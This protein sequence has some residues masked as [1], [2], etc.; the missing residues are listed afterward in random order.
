MPLIVLSGDEAMAN[1]KSNSAST[2]PARGAAGSRLEPLARPRFSPSFQLQPGE[3]IFTIG[4]CF[5]RNI[6]VMLEQAGFVIPTRAIIKAHAEFSRIGHNVLNN[7]GAPSI[8][9]EIRWALDDQHPFVEE[10]AFFEIYPG[11]YIDAHLNHALKPDALEDVRARRAAILSCYRAISECRVIIITLGLAECWLDRTTGIYLNTAP[12]RS[13]IREFP[14]RFELHVLSYD[15]VLSAMNAAMELIRTHGHPEARVILTVSPVPLTSTFRRDDVMVANTYSKA[16]LRT[17][18]EAIT[19]AYDFVDY[20]PSYESVTLSERSVALLEDQVHPSPEVIQLNTSRMIRAYVGSDDQAHFDWRD[21]IAKNPRT[22]LSILSSRPDLVESDADLA[23]E[24]FRVADSSGRVDLFPAILPHVHDR[25]PDDEKD[26]ALARIALAR[27]DYAAALE[28]ARNEP[29]RRAAR[30]TFWRTR[31]DIHLAMDDITAARAAA[32]GWTEFNPRAPE[33]L[34]RMG[35]AYAERGN[36]ADA[37]AMFTAALAIA[38]RDPRVLMD[39]AAMLIADGR[40]AEAID[41]LDRTVP[42]TPA[43]TE[44]LERLRLWARSDAPDTTGASKRAEAL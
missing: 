4:S 27:R 28:K 10:T 30:G 42:T 44:N 19:H 5:A 22:A 1:V 25:L 14:D 43:Q 26:L 3:K 39:Y 17:V 23:A 24:V 41:Y 15:E 34:R 16:V 20:Y 29:Q 33:P 32:R 7:Y 18:A 11:K 12:R 38:D 37:E 21:E 36:L 8:L 35:V 31:I 2:W 6:E 13:M 9:N 40:N